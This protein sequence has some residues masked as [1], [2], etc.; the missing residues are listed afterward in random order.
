MAF[1]QKN[2]FTAPDIKDILA[3][4]RSAVRTVMVLFGAGIVLVSVL[5]GGY[6]IGQWILWKT[7]PQIMT[8]LSPHETQPLITVQSRLRELGTDT[9][10]TYDASSVAARTSELAPKNQKDAL[11][12]SATSTIDARMKELGG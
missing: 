9:N 7:A 2:P 10:A 3:E 11:A 12:P 8:P 1:F 6:Q 4:K 5:L